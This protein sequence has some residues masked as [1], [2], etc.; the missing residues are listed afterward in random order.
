MSGGLRAPA[1]SNDVPVL[2]VSRGVLS[3]HVKVTDCDGL[4]NPGPLATYRIKV[5]EDG[6]PSAVITFP[7]GERTSVPFGEWCVRY[8][9]SDDYG[10]ERAWLYWQVLKGA[11]SD[12]VNSSAE[13]EEV[14][15]TEVPVDREL[16]IQQGESVLKLART[17]AKPGDLV[18]VWLAAAD[19]RVAEELPIDATHL[20]GLAR[21]TLV[22]FN[23]V[24]ESEKIRQVQERLSEVEEEIGEMRDRQRRVKTFV[25]Q[26]R[27][28]VE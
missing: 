19:G 18:E 12:A 22:R 3:F 5:L 7:K 2:A 10:V 28:R 16:T 14:G 25:E 24:D 20:P 1:G 23:I 11:R 4:Q 8:K 26:I 21:S 9:M 17:E 13:A 15:R 27:E 6:A